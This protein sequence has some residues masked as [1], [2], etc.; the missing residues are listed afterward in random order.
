ME[1]RMQRRRPSREILEGDSADVYFYRAQQVL[2]REGIDPVVVME[3]FS[4]QSGVLCG[5]DE[6]KVLLAH[7]LHETAPEDTVVEALSDGDLFGEREIVLRI[8]SR[9]R[10]FGLY[11]TAILGMMAQST[12]WATAA[13]RCVE[14]AAPQPVISFG[15]RHVHPD[16]SDT[17][18]YAAIV[19]G[20]VG[21]STPA[22]ARLSG[23]RPT[24]TMPHALVLMFG[25]TV[26][27]AEAFDRDLPP[28]VPRIVLVDTFKDEAEEALRVADALGDRLYGIRLD[29]PSERGRV[30]ADLVTEIRARLDQAGYHHVK[31]IVSGG[32]NPD[33]I[34]YFKERGAP[35]DSFAVGS[36]ISG[37]SP[38]DFTG[39]LKEIDGHPIAKRGRIPGITPSPRLR[40]IDLADWLGE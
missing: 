37:A 17:L 3:V 23:L 25:D 36:Y 6:A 30:T 28:D 2:E 16:V 32:L 22:G 21:A 31:I 8:R 24:G 9:Y 29:T 35:V 20:C 26:R 11:E 27:A 1:V 14:A 13:R 4:R 18:D 5:I 7:A 15:A 38:I 12:G 10:R 34:M 19:G 33:R 40:P 39:D